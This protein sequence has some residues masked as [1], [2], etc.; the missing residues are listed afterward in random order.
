MRLERRQNELTKVLERKRCGICR[1]EITTRRNEAVVYRKPQ[2]GRVLTIPSPQYI[3]V[4]C[5]VH[6][7]LLICGCGG[8]SPTLV[9]CATIQETGRIVA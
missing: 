9:L 2:N 4:L 3:S 7:V 5:R 1:K 6:C 8:C